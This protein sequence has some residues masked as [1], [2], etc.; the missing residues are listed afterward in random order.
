[1]IYILLLIMVSLAI[2]III[3]SINFKLTKRRHERKAGELRHL[4]VEETF[5]A[6]RRS[7]IVA[8]ANEEEI[9]FA[10]ANNQLQSAIAAFRHDAVGKLADEKL[11][12]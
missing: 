2:A 4:M 12:N 11:L 6:A 1:M 5:N 9:R 7:E 8:M 10:M 3:L